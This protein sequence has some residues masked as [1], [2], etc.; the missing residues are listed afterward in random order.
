MF[1]NQLTIKK[2]HQGLIKKEFSSVELT[3]SVLRQV[4]K[5]NQ[6]VNA[7]LTITEEVALA[8]ANKVDRKIA[9]K[10]EI[11]FLEGV[12]VA[13]KDNMLVDEIKCTAASKF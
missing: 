12:P 9:N 2:A 4:K 13:I 10:E 5:R 1:L 8:Q 11:G 6:E 7:Y 3:E